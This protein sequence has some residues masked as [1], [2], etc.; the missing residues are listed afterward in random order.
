MP[1]VVG[2]L[3]TITQPEF[4]A[5]SAVVNPIPPGHGPGR[6]VAL[7]WA[8]RLTEP[9]GVICTIVVPVPCRLSLLLKLL[10]RIFPLTSDPVVTGTRTIPYG[11]TSPLLGTVEAMVLMLLACAPD[12]ASTVISITATIGAMRG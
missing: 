1:S 11:F 4:K 7:I 9:L 3:P 12:T 10:T 6:L 5:T 8:N 2:R